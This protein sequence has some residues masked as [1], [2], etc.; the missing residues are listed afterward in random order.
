MVKA[1]E[2]A[3]AKVGAREWSQDQAWES[4]LKVARGL[5]GDE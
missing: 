2:E 4:V 3:R 5:H 1:I